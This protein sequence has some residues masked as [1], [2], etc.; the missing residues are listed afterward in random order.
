L[1]RNSSTDEIPDRVVL[2]EDDRVEARGLGAGDE[3][4]RVQ[5]AVVGT[6][7]RMCVE[8]DE[9]DAERHYSGGPRLGKR[10]GR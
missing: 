2:R 7:P 3:V 10:G 5:D 9:H 6:W 4:V 1:A 8:V